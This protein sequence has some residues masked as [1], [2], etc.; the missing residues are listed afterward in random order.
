MVLKERY[1][2]GVVGSDKPLSKLTRGRGCDTYV[3]ILGFLFTRPV[4]HPLLQP[5]IAQTVALECSCEHIPTIHQALN[6]VYLP[7]L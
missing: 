1:S 7:L 2:D 3:M 6:C 5:S 4:M